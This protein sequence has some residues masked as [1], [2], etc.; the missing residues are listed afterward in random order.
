MT[1][2]L[3][4]ARDQL[5]ELAEG[6]TTSGHVDLRLDGETAHLVLDHRKRRHALTMQ[7]MVQL[8]D[9]VRTLSA[10]PGKQLVLSCSG[11]PVF[12]AG[13]DLRQLGRISP[14]VAQRMSRAMTT[15]LDAML[16]LP[17]LS[18][19]AIDGLA[20]GGG[21]ELVTAC[22][23]RV[24]ASRGAIH[25]VQSRLGIAP[26]W[27]GTGRLV[28]HL[29]RRGALRILSGGRR[30]RMGE[31]EQLGLVDHRVDGDVVQG[32]LAWLAPLSEVP[33]VALRA[34]KE[35]V[36]AAAPAREHQGEAEVFARVWGGPDH[37]AALAGLE[38]HRR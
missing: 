35:Q 27:G 10:W 7:M 25:F 36:V 8:A 20:V 9:H 31:A 16:D 22:D 37:E 30:L 14:E 11:G 3:T 34:V 29:G 4:D 18:V 19:A 6:T 26:G 32:T 15:V 1:D 2:R 28:R 23:Y 21:A 38:R 5:A 24:G 12:C 17:V 33:T 13:G